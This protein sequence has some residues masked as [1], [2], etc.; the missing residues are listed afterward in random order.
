MDEHGLGAGRLGLLVDLPPQPW[1]QAVANWATIGCG[2]QRL[3]VDVSAVAN[4]NTGPAIYDST[5]AGDW[6]RAGWG[7]AGGT[8]VAAP[9]VGAEF[10]LAGGARGVGYP[11]QTLYSHAGDGAA[12]EDVSEGSNGSCVGKAT[13]CTATVGYDGP[14]GL[15]TPVGLS[16]FALPGVPTL[17]RL[18]GVSGVAMAGRRLALH[19]GSWGSAPT[20]AGYQWEDCTHGETGCLPIEGATGSSYTLSARDVNRTVRVMETAGNSSGYSPPAFSPAT[21][22]VRPSRRSPRAHRRRA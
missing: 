10:A 22:T 7:H 3:S 16:A 4:P 12:F 15:G 2:A 11:A 9:I 13:V 6:S 8:S 20:S 17:E 18:P 14:S 19:P 1:Q 21:R 5:P